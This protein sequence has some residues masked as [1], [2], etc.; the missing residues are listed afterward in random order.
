MQ[1]LLDNWPWVL[2]YSLIF[3]LYVGIIA[4]LVLT[5]KLGDEVNATRFN[6]REALLQTSANTCRAI[7]VNANK[8]NALA[9]SVEGLIRAIDEMGNSIQPLTGYPAHI[10]ATWEDVGARGRF[11]TDLGG[12]SVDM[13]QQQQD[14]FNRALNTPLTTE[15]AA[16]SIADIIVDLDAWLTGQTEIQALTWGEKV[17]RIK[18]TGN[19]TT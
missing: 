7:T 11:L 9:T 19:G 12:M 16:G 4:N 8:V 14:E 10:E 1:F 2:L 15:P 13:R 6:Q 5:R 3:L 18:G 17:S